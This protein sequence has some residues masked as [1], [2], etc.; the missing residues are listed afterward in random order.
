MVVRPFLFAAL[1]L[2]V[3]AVAVPAEL[4][5][6]PIVIPREHSVVGS[7]VNLVLDPTEVPFFQVIIG[8]TEYPVVDTSSGRHAYQGIELEPGLNT[9]TLK[10]FAPPAESDAK[11]NAAE[12][13]APDKG[14]AAGPENSTR[15]L[16][17][18]AT[19]TRQVFSKV[20]LLPRR[21]APAGFQRDPFHSRERETSCA[22]CHNLEA[23]PRDAGPPQKPE[24]LICSVC[25]RKVPT[26]KH[27]HGPVAVWNCLACHNPDAQPVKYQFASAD[28]WKVKK[29]SRAVKPALFT[30]PADALFKPQTAVLLSEDAAALPGTGK[31][32]GKDQ[33]RAKAREAELSRMKE[34]QRKLFAPLLDHLALN[35]ADRILVE[36][37]ADAAPL[38][39]EKGKKAKGPKDYQQLTD[40]RAK[41]LERVLKEYGITGTNRVTVAGRGSAQPTS[42]GAA[43]KGEPLNNRIEIVAFPQDVPVRNSRDL[44]ALN[45]LERV[46]V[47]VSSSRGAEVRG[48]KV[49]ERVPPG[50]QYVKGSGLFRGNTKDP[51]IKGDELVWEIGDRGA[52]FQEGISYVL[53]K[54]K[55][56][57]AQVSPAVRLLFTSGQ[58]EETKDIDPAR[59]DKRGLTVVESCKTCH[60]DI[61]AGP[62]RHGPAEAGYCTVCH[63]PHASDYSAWTR[64]S[65]RRL[66]T[67]CHA[68]KK[69]GA[70][71]IAGV[72]SR[73]SHP[74]KKK[75]DPARPGKRL[76]CVSCH[77]PHS[78]YTR[79]LL[80]F[81]VRDKFE[82]CEYCH[83]RK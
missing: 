16:K 71:V 54:E 35:P 80:A 10:V 58:R 40:A 41:A 43:R 7:R 69:T 63:D 22:G 53:K 74:T 44:P 31:D 70:H 55:G 67:T 38:P 42:S 83:P 57:S 2:C 68:E 13:R 45:D 78:A 64:K 9:I 8:K 32:K 56:A 39:K 36:V 49:V 30:I 29:T 81:G 14:A 11:Q 3:P 52:D 26:G 76:S 77:A 28:P 60:P 47:T 1:F 66:C 51:Q 37:H 59:S 46:T 24:D 12:E 62:S 19:W 21:P 50:M 27:V 5:T 48:L 17:L 15:G 61:L 72:G 18:V 34:Q 82:I 65:S 33:E 23:P 75:A 79:E 73:L 25:H 6:S 20:E 4:P